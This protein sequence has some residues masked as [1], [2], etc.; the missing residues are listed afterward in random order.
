MHKTNGVLHT[1]AAAFFCLFLYVCISW[2]CCSSEALRVFLKAHFL[3]HQ[4]FHSKCTTEPIGY[5]GTASMTHTSKSYE[6]SVV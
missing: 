1:F 3:Q 4:N 5:H 6:K 2:L